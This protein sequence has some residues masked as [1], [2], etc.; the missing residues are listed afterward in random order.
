MRPWLYPVYFRFVGW[1]EKEKLKR[2]S[3]NPDNPDA[4]LRR[5]A[6]A[7]EDSSPP[8]CSSSVCMEQSL[9]AMNL[10]YLLLLWACAR[11]GAQFNLILHPRCLHAP[12]F[13]I[14]ELATCATYKLSVTSACGSPAARQCDIQILQRAAKGRG[15]AMHHSSLG[16]PFGEIS[17]S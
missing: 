4:V 1:A 17:L 9:L 11:L 5:G 6:S 13:C 2:C 14:L 8:S 16:F 12:T 15:R 3:V 7:R 10:D